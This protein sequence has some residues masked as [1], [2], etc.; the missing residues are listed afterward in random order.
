M[1]KNPLQIFI[2]SNEGWTSK[3]QEMIQDLWLGAWVSERSGDLLRSPAGPGQSL[4]MGPK[5]ENDNFEPT[6]S[7]SSD[8]KNL[9]LSLNFVG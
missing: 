7:F 6:T 1:W 5:G 3:I 9:T 8:E 4:G 2:D